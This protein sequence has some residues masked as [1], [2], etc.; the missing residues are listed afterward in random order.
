MK[1]NTTVKLTTLLAVILFAGGI[2]SAQSTGY[3]NPTDTA[4]PH[5]W[6]NPLNGMV[7]DNQWATAPH[8]SGCNCPFIYLS[9]NKGANYTSPAL[10]GPFGDVD[11]WRVAG[12]PTDTFSHHW[13][14]SEFSNTNFRVK[15]ANSSTLITQGYRDFNLVIPPGSKIVGIEVNMQFHGDSSFTTDFLN[16]FQVDVFYSV[17]TGIAS[18]GAFINNIEIFPNPAHNN[19]TLQVTGLSELKYSLFS[20]DGRLVMEKNAGTISN[21]YKSTINL[22]AIPAG[23]YIIKLE[24]NLGT[25]Y[26]KVVVQ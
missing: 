19:L 3:M 11:S 7:S 23:I 12:S 14:D 20:I 22:D 13:V 2:V 25:E 24:S 8:T 10:D 9:W 17:T 6:T 1:K 18:T 5:G 15:I 16:A 4:L 21:D 26:R